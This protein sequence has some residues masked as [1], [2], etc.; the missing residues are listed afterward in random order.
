[1]VINET[2]ARLAF[3]GESAI[4]KR[5]ACCEPGEGGPD[6]PSWKTVVGVVADVSP[7]SPGAPVNPQFYLP[8]DQVPEAA[9]DWSSRTLGLVL[10]SAQAP[11][12][13]VPLVR[14]AVRAVDPT[15]PVYDV[16][17]M[18]ERRDRTMAQ[19]RFGA[20]LLSALGAVGLLLAAVGIYGVVAFFVGDRTREIAVRLALGAT[21]RDVT[22]L[23]L[24]QGMG[25]VLAGLALGLVGAVAAGRALGSVLF[26]VGTVDPPTLAAVAAL[27]LVVSALASVV[28]ARR[29]ARVDPSRALANV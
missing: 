3:P 5:I 19:E 12:A 11:S 14:Q 28:P 2:L 15:V 16:Q 1:M 24:R 10:R 21:P 7:S 6:T 8:M 29:A 9:W 22:G 26:G 20:A 18:I 13:I 23:V 17:T 4:S 25:P 27:L